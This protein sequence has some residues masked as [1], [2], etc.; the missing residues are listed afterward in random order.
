MPE[1]RGH[2]CSLITLG[3]EAVA[4]TGPEV[5]FV[6]DY[7]GTVLETALWRGKEGP[8]P[9]A[10]EVVVPI[11]ESGERHLYLATSAKFPSLGSKDTAVRLEDGVSVALDT[12]AK[13][14]GG[15]YSVDWNCEGA[16]P[17]D[18]LAGLREDGMVRKIWKHTER[19]LERASVLDGGL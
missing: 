15:V 6:H 7:P 18:L 12:R 19:E 1:L 10:I 11:E 13:I 8:P 3:L 16:A 4:E 5:S 14:G 17:L 2:L 9:S